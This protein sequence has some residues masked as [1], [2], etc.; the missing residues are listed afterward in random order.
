[1][2]KYLT[3]V[4]ETLLISLIK[5]SFAVVVLKYEYILIK[6]GR[7]EI[8]RKNVDG[9]HLH[10]NEILHEKSGKIGLLDFAVALVRTYTHTYIRTD[11]ILR[12]CHNGISL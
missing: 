10:H 12:P 5:Q 6:T 8:L 4:V 7:D 1:M 9:A 11:E 2:A 3:L